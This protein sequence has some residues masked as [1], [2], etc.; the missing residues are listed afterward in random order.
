VLLKQQQ[1]PPQAGRKISEEDNAKLKA[2][3]DDAQFKAAQEPIQERILS[4]DAKQEVVN[5]IRSCAGE[6]ARISKFVPAWFASTQDENRAR[7]FF[8]LVSQN[9][10]QKRVGTYLSSEPVC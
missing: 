10:V 6:W 1:Q 3:G 8:R 7:M 9:F 4:N 2:I 5:K